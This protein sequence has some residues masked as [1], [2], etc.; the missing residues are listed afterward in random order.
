MLSTLMG[1]ISGQSS[2]YG[3]DIILRLLKNGRGEPCHSGPHRADQR[4][5]KGQKSEYDSHTDESQH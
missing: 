1:E 4:D 3:S 2:G 5:Q